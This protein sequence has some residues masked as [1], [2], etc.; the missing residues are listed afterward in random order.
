MKPRIGILIATY[1][2]EKYLEKQIESL[3]NQTCQTFKVFI[4]DDLSTDNTVS[5]I[6]RY[7]KKDPNK[8][9]LV[10][11]DF[12]N[13]GCSKSFMNLVENCSSDYI[14]LCDQD[15]VWFP[16]K[17]AD[18][19][20]SILDLE[21]RNPNLPAMVFSDLKVVDGNL[22][23]ISNSFWGFQKLDP[24]VA[25]H[26]KKSLAQSTVTGCTMMFNQKAKDCSLPF[27]LP[28]MLHDHWISV[29]VAK[30]GVVTYIKEP[31]MLY[32]QHGSNVLG[33][34]SFSMKYVMSK[35]KNL[36]NLFIFYKKAII[37]YKDINAFELVY[38][39]VVVNLKR[40][41]I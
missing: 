11:D 27:E 19:L 23:Y 4:R 26:W 10:E 22:D 20:S 12:G 24:K 25:K 38:F 31:T 3:L 30:Y 1:N 15:D 40:L 7:V 8:F 37:F 13:L 29:N 16:T 33:A 34:L 28:S 35:Y 21:K 32:C 17:V 36:L 18:T 41:L 6:K 9:C 5:L 14:M 39:K 2:G